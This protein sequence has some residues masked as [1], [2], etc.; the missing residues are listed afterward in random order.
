[1]V[2]SGLRLSEIPLG[3]M[4]NLEVTERQSRLKSMDTPAIQDISCPAENWMDTETATNVTLSSALCCVQ[5]VCQYT[6]VIG[7]YSGYYG[8]VEGYTC[9]QERSYG[10]IKP[11]CQ[12][13]LLR[14]EDGYY[15]YDDVT[16]NVTVWDTYCR[17]S[18]N[19]VCELKGNNPPSCYDAGLAIGILHDFSDASF[20]RETCVPPM[21]WEVA[22]NVTYGSETVE[23]PS[24]C[25][26]SEEREAVVAMQRLAILHF[27]TGDSTFVKEVD[28]YR[29]CPLSIP[30]RAYQDTENLDLMGVY[31][32][33]IFSYD[34]YTVIV[35]PNDPR[36]M[37]GPSNVAAT[38]SYSVP[39]TLYGPTPSFMSDK[40]NHPTAV[41]GGS[42]MAETDRKLCAYL[43]EG[44]YDR[45]ILLRSASERFDIYEKELKEQCAKV[46][47]RFF[48][49]PIVEDN[50]EGALKAALKTSLNTVMYI[51][52]YDDLFIET[53]EI[54][55]SLGLLKQGSTWLLPHGNIGNSLDGL[56][57]STKKLLHGS[58]VI[59]NTGG[60]NDQ[61]DLFMKSWKDQEFTDDMV[62][63]YPHEELRKFSFSNVDIEKSQHLRDIGTYAYDS[64]LA[65]AFSMCHADYSEFKGRVFVT[66]FLEFKKQL[67]PNLK[68]V[69]FTGLSGRVTYNDNNERIMEAD[70]VKLFTLTKSGDSF[71]MTE[72]GTFNED[73]AF[74]GSGIMVYNGNTTEKPE[75]KFVPVEDRGYDPQVQIVILSFGL[76]NLV[77]CAFLCIWVHLYRRHTII[78]ASQATFLMATLLGAAISSCSIFFIAV[79]DEG[80]PIAG[81]DGGNTKADVACNVSVWFYSL[82]FVLTFAALFA[83]MW[84]ID[85]IFNSDSDKM[86]RQKLKGALTDRALF[87]FLAQLLSIDLLLLIVWAAVDPLIYTRNI[88]EADFLGDTISSSGSCS[89]EYSSVFIGLIGAYHFLILAWGSSV[90]HRVKD[91]NKSFAEA[92]HI[93]AAMLSNLQ[94]LLVGVPVLVIISD[95]SEAINQYVRG[96]VIFL[97]DLVVLMLIFGPKMQAIYFGTSGKGL[98]ADMLTLGL[99]DDNGSVK[100]STGSVPLTDFQSTFRHT[101]DYSDSITSTE[102]RKI[103]PKSFTKR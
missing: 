91:V 75:V 15:S 9:V 6:S 82:G 2:A 66:N 20:T 33:N 92:K 86:R 32:A 55:S 12:C 68:K 89:S 31:G 35:G 74:M 42:R 102:S 21:R 96:G 25:M 18:Q 61:Y 71:S 4:P 90:A 65:M 46:G 62:R 43:K 38:S 56:Q 63:G 29:N 85:Q 59:E 24:R 79:T 57:E 54:S 60:H 100:G 72:S 77:V 98:G 50:V 26:F 58:I 83:K 93:T 49:H 10:G 22:S 69:N 51:G 13:S 19:Q 37:G 78:I 17:C 1:M 7:L 39:Y 81:P 28:N 64:I 3:P 84:R 70:S 103:L 94:V 99:S 67:L 48:D 47:V 76:I 80:G 16:D 30:F 52:E 27:N 95:S 41:F 36:F 11:L 44:G 34:E 101:E 8:C 73:N 87:T 88:V 5:S 45:V 14:P 23:L 97:N 53:I 40:K